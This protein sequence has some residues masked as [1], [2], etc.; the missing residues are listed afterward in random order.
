MRS[1]PG[2]PNNLSSGTS[3]VQGAAVILTLLLAA[4]PWAHAGKKPSRVPEKNPAPKEAVGAPAETALTSV[5]TGLNEVATGLLLYRIRNGSRADAMK[6]QSGDRVTHIN[7]QKVRSRSDASSAFR[8]ISPGSRPSAVV[9]RGMDVVPRQA[10]P[11]P[12]KKPVKRGTRDLSPFEKVFKDRRLAEMAKAADARIEQAP[13]LDFQLRSRQSVW[14]RFPAGIPLSAA[15][16]TV[17]EGVTTTGVSTDSNLDYLSIPPGT[18]LWGKLLPASGPAGTRNIRILFFK[19]RLKGGNFYSIAA[20][21]SDISGDPKQWK[22]SPGGTIVLARRTDFPPEVRVKIEFIKPVTLREP[23]SFFQAGPGLWLKSLENGNFVISHVI[24]GRSAEHAGL[25]VG[26][27]VTRIAGKRSGK[28]DF[29]SALGLL[30][31]K[32]GSPLKLDISR[33]E[34][35]KARVKRFKLTRGVFYSDNAELRVPMPY[36]KQREQRAEAE[37]ALDAVRREKAAEKKRKKKRR[38]KKRRVR[39]RKSRR[40][41][42]KKKDAPKTV[43]SLK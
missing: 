5:G 33:Q 36:V 38:V 29:P 4:A 8:N 22:V 41:R 14:L 3:P 6:L 17:V 37:K 26:Q 39:R 7:L 23:E 18:T 32:P 43:P 12:L 34:R 35:D 1:H 19:M 27:T 21:S 24:R 15:P 42:P 40:P 10:K 30:Y 16:G 28:L 31:G 11:A 25:K 13:S 9:L 2:H 20:R